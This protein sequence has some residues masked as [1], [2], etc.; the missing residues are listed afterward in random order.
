MKTYAVLE[1]GGKQYRV[2]PG[3][4]I[5]VERI[6]GEVGQ[7]VTLTHVLALGG[8]EPLQVGAPQLDDAK[9]VCEIADVKRGPKLINFK[10]KRR[11]GYHRKVGH[12]QDL[13]V[14][15]VKSVG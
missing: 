7:E 11:K 5:E 15:K 9:V 13:V 10:K 6:E 1:T 3:D 14:L 12:R 4:A 8:E 2:S